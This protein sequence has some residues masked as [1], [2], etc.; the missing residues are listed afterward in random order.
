MSFW[1]KFHIPSLL[2]YCFGLLVF[3]RVYFSAILIEKGQYF[4]YWCLETGNF[5][6]LGQEK[7]KLWQFCSGKCRH[8]APLME[9][10]VWPWASLS[11]KFV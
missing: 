10:L 5:G 6:K 3:P 4:G 2:R 9:N 1:Y 11:P 8:N 7:A